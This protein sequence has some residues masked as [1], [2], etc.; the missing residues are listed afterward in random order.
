MANLD[1]KFEKFTEVTL[2]TAAH[3]RDEL[4]DEVQKE[5]KQRIE[6]IENKHLEKAYKTVQRGVASAQKQAAEQVSLLASNSRRELLAYRETLIAELFDALKAE[7]IKFKQDTAY[8][9]FLRQTIADGMAA[10]GAGD[11]QVTMDSTDGAYAGLVQEICGVQPDYRDGL[12]GGAIVAS[13]EQKRICDNTLRA[14]I[15]TAREGFLEWSK[16]SILQ[17][18]GDAV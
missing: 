14:K 6:Q 18:T 12:L 13:F 15:E 4:L 10:V 11:V 5:R 3:R 16:F 2:K 1:E 17:G 9:D 7:V 8:R